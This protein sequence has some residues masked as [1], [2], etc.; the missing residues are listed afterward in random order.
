[1]GDAVDELDILLEAE[2]PRMLRRR[3]G[4]GEA[5]RI[6]TGERGTEAERAEDALGPVDWARVRRRRRQ[7]AVAAGGQGGSVRGGG[8]SGGGGGRG[9]GV[10][11]GGGGGGGEMRGRRRRR[12]RGGVGE[13]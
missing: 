2:R 9:G 11:R 6:G 7:A 10:L 1:M 8:A 13:G 4:R 3:R 5:G 12:W